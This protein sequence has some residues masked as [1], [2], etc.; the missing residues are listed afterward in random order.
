MKLRLLVDSNYDGETQFEEDSQTA[1]LTCSVQAHNTACVQCCAVRS[2]QSFDAKTFLNDEI[3]ADVE[4][5]AKHLLVTVSGCF[6]D[7]RRLLKISFN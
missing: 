5:G 3:V 7:Q 4:E 2:V 1:R 6:V